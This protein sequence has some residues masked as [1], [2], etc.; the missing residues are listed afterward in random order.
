[1]SKHK[2]YYDYLQGIYGI[3]EKM[4]YDRRTDY[5]AKPNEFS[6]KEK[7]YIIYT[8]A[9]CNRLFIIYKYGNK[10]YHTAEEILELD[11]L[12]TKDDDTKGI[13]S[14]WARRRN[15]KDLIKNAE[16]L[17]NSNNV[18]I[19][20]NKKVR[21]P[22]LIKTRDGEFSCPLT[23]ELGGYYG[24]RVIKED[25]YWSIPILSEYGVASVYPAEKIYQD[26]SSFLGWLVD[27]PPIPNN[28]TNDEKILSHGFDLK[29]SFRHRKN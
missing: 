7:D 13:L 29:Q 22:V 19:D 28:Q 25:A 3:D 23:R 11:D 6:E 26:I 12:L 24:K 16:N 27:N 5:L 17:Y 10:Y 15:K 1:M 8:L 21:Q 2:D 14:V 4:I 20:V 9:I 18:E